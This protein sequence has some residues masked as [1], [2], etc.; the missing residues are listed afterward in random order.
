MA[1]RFTRRNLFGLAGVAALGTLGLAARRSILHV[2][3]AAGRSV[4]Q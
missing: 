2:Q 1:I 4:S 3:D